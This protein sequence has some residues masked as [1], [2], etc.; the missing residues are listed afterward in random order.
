METTHCKQ[1]RF[2][3]S[4]ML[5]SK[6]VVLCALIVDFTRS[7]VR[8]KTTN[9]LQDGAGKWSRQHPMIALLSRHLSSLT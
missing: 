2:G 8:T 5:S 7:S 4:A 1:H 6:Q 9:E 3:L